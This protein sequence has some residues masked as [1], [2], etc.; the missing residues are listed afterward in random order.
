MELEWCAFRIKAGR[1]F[2]KNAIKVY[3]CKIFQVFI[4][5]EEIL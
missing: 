2:H 1:S 3:I 5:T 4:F